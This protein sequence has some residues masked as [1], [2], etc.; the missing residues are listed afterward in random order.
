M[1]LKTISPEAAQALLAQGAVLVDIRPAD[2][3]ARMR[4]PQAQHVPLPSLHAP[5]T[6][7]ERDLPVIFHCRSGAR[8]Q[9]NAEAL[10]QCA[11]CDAYAL[12]GG[13]DAWVRAGLPVVRD[14]R[15][16]IEL[17]RQVQLAA[18]ML[19]FMGTVLGTTVS[20]WFYVLP[21]FVGA[22]L[23]FA[24]ATGLCGLAR[25]LVKAPWNRRALAP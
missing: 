7:F 20:P 19:V 25:L 21:G 11:G 23:M 15:A 10:A 13:L 2:E 9:M 12:E 16:P 24:G 5:A 22:G 3:H 6:R 1:P 4:I 8:T 17:Q 14:A 18:G